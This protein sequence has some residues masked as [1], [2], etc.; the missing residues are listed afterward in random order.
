MKKGC[1]FYWKSMRND[2]LNYI[3]KCPI[4]IRSKKSMK[5]NPLPKRIITIGPRERY[6]CR[7]MEN[8]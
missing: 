3:N 5:I 8:S 1:Y 6:V 2:V 4:C 7:W